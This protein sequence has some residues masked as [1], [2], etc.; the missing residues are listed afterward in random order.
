MA[1]RRAE[2]PLGGIR[3]HI[4]LCQLNAQ[5]LKLFSAYPRARRRAS[6]G[7]GGYQC[8][9]REAAHTVSYYIVHSSGKLNQL[10]ALGDGF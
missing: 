1:T 6:L 4:G 2:P 5:S 7:A 9:M 8:A 10:F 3:S